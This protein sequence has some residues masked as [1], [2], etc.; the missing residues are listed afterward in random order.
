MNLKYENIDDCIKIF[1]GLYSNSR[2][3][4]KEEKI[5]L[6]EKVYMDEAK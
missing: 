2:T 1:K 4:Y 6:P 3:T 5:D